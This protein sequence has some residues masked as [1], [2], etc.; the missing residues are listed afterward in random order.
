MGVNTKLKILRAA[1]REFAENGYRKTTIRTI[2]Q[3]AAVNVAAVNYHFSGKSELYC[4]T[5]DWLMEAVCGNEIALSKDKSPSENIRLWVSECIQ[6]QA[7]GRTWQNELALKMVF[8]ELQGPSDNYDYF[9]QSRILPDLEVLR[10]SIIRGLGRDISET[11]V[12]IRLF[13]LIGKAI[14]YVFHQNVVDRFGGAD[15][16]KKHQEKIIESIVAE[17]TNDFTD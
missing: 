12:K 14:F 1:A 2:C 6:S 10:D 9:Y 17:A 11:D 15:F 4:H 7:T 13:A 8:H 3:K 5:F 16:L